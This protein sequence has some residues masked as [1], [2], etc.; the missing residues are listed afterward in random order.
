MPPC[1]RRG[2]H[3]KHLPAHKVC[4][5]HELSKRL[6]QLQS[7]KLFIFK[8]PFLFF[9]LCPLRCEMK[10][11]S[12]SICEAAA[13]CLSVR[14]SVGLRVPVI[15]PHQT[16]CQLSVPANRQKN[17]A[18]RTPQRFHFNFSR[19]KKANSLPTH[20]DTRSAILS[21]AVRSWR[22]RRESPPKRYVTGRWPS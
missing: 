12:R 13:V 5:M 10:A 22:G 21:E 4:P 3:S 6:S 20:R 18:S 9:F 17:D 19:R 7:T 1:T 15:S 11:S 8:T 2:N 14:P 16:V